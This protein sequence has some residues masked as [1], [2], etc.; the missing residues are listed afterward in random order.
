M[1]IESSDNQV[2]RDQKRSAA[3][4]FFTHPLGIVCAASG[5][6]LLWGSAFPMIKL[7]YDQLNIGSTDIFHQLLFAGY[8][9][10]LASLLIIGFMLLLRKKL[11]WQKNN[12]R[13]LLIIALF[14]TFLQYVF[15]YIG[16]GFS[17][18][19]QG[20]II[21][22]TTSF[23][24]IIIAHFMYKN[25]YLSV[26][27]VMGM[28]IGFMGVIL[29]SST[30]GTIKLAIGLGEILLLF[31]M[32]A[33]AMGNILAKNAAQKLDIF[34][35]TCVQMLIGST[36]LIAI[37]ASQVG[38]FPFSFDW[39]SGLILFY[40]AFLSAAGFVLWNTV[41]K[42]NKV[43]SISTY[44]FLIPVFGVFLSSLL[45]NERMHGYVLISLFLVIL[46]IIIVNRKEKEISIKS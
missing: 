44:L 37:G 31:A 22:G 25:D 10:F 40:L 36:G 3:E 8:R 34:Y 28:L 12:G 43:G 32:F 4:R 7:S 41:M 9:F 6:T 23:F 18:G 1:S 14:Q 2:D 30:G 16:L 24:Q 5:A 35:M 17:T 11:S 20:S 13:T 45:L 29:V 39:T 21:A 19:V 46:G 38:L 15:F 42:Y 27:K 26:R 33:G